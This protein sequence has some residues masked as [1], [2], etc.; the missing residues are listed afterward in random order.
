MFLGEGKRT[1]NIK[2]KKTPAPLQPTENTGSLSVNYGE[3]RY[4]KI[5][6]LP[7]FR[8]A[9]GNFRLQPKRTIKTLRGCQHYSS[10]SSAYAFTERESNS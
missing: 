10:K 4:F 9:H 6:N 3:K 7:K 5:S 1:G 2:N 8:K